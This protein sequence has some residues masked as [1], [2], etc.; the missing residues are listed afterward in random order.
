MM[1]SP[2]SNTNSNYRL[3]IDGL[4]AIAVLSVLGFHFFPAWIQGGFIGVDIFFVISGYLIS[5]ILFEEIANGQFSFI[6]F[7]S[8]RI[9]RIFPALILI[10]IVSMALGWLILFD[11]E[12]KKLGFHVVAGGS[13]FSNFAYWN[14]SGYFDNAP[15]TK[16]LLHLWSLGIEEQFYI[17][18]PFVIWLAYK[19]NRLTF[20]LILFAFCLSLI[21]CVAETKAHPVATFYLPLTR[22][23][24]LLS[25]SLLAYFVTFNSRDKLLP[26]LPLI[27]QISRINLFNFFSILGMILI[28]S[29]FL[30]INKDIGFPGFWASLPVLGAT[31]ILAAGPQA[32]LNRVV[33]SHR[34]LVWIGLISYP[35]YLWH[36]ILLSFSSIILGG[37]PSRSVRVVLLLLSFLVGWL[38]YQLAEKPLRKSKNLSLITA[39]LSAFML[40]TILAGALIY[41]KD[42][43]PARKNIP[44]ISI[45]GELDHAFFYQYI[46]ERNAPCENQRILNGAFNTFGYIRCFQSKSNVNIDT[47]IIGDSH[48]EHLF[49]GLSSALPAQNV[50]YYMLSPS[51]T[52]EHIRIAA[53]S[54]P[55]L[56]LVILSL[57]WG[58]LSGAISNQEFQKLLTD[59]F[60]RNVKVYLLLDNPEFNF[61][62]NQCIEKRWIYSDKPSCQMSAK[63]W[64]D[65][66]NDSQAAVLNLLQA[67]PKTKIIDIGQYFCN[68]DTCN[69]A[70]NKKILMRDAHHLNVTGSLYIGNAIANTINSTK[71][72][73][74]ILIQK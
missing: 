65:Q 6:H 7:Y 74:P 39:S 2:L 22:F 21:A 35:L 15:E 30:L 38:S 33:L 37:F 63:Q 59:L 62:P 53:N 26:D 55:T 68:D 54:D 50:G 70:L 5:L 40:M 24:E 29:G 10:L 71:N 27:T 69:M 72:E 1:A 11:Y 20:N 56:K 47:L 57:Y 51:N 60:N 16:P 9:R 31:C 8:R 14:E 44:L 25:G 66:K 46:S 67:F 49:P 52:F 23:W 34:L 4:R 48:A 19:L 3:D 58:S 13:F 17:F 41:F 73:E 18:W 36:W 42:G 45:P 12:Y 64:H 61:Q 32:W 28:V 43:F